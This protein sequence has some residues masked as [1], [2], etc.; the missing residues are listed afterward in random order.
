[1]ADVAIVIG[2]YGRRQQMNVAMKFFFV[3]TV[4]G[5]VG[6]NIGVT[7]MSAGGGEPIILFL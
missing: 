7:M 3:T 4:R 2:R 1:V 5:V 6:F